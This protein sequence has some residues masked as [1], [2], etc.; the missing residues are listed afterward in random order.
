MKVGL[1]VG[2]IE[3]PPLPKYRFQKICWDIVIQ[4]YTSW[5]SEIK[6]FVPNSREIGSL[7]IK[8]MWR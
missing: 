2:G 7:L 1:G 8:V 4:I 3:E 5:N 6:Y